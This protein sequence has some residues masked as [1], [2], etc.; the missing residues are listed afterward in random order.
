[1]ESSMSDPITSPPKTYTVVIIDNAHY[2]EPETE[3]AVDGFATLDEAIAFARNRVRSSVE[4]LRSPGI[5]KIDLRKLWLI[6]GE[7][8]FV[9][10]GHY[11]GSDE[12]DY[13]IEHQ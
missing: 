11:S 6:Y 10:G 4:E 13:F 1:M 7:N 9:I 8:A 3:R 5:S 12:V 2:M